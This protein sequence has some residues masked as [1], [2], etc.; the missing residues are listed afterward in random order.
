MNP[1]ETNMKTKM[2]RQTV[3]TAST[4][5]LASSTSPKVCPSRLLRALLP[6]VF[7][8]FATPVLALDGALDTTWYAG[9]RMISYV[10]RVFV[11]PAGHVYLSSEDSFPPGPGGSSSLIRLNADGS[12]DDSF[13]VVVGV[14]RSPRLMFQPDGKIIYGGVGTDWAWNCFGRLNENGAVD[15][16]H[17]FW[18]PALWAQVNDMVL[19]PDGKIV[20]VGV[21]DTEAQPSGGQDLSAS[22]HHDI[23]RFNAD[24]TWDESFPVVGGITDRGGVPAQFNATALALR[25]DGKILVGGSFAYIGGQRR[26]AIARLNPDG[27]LD[28]DFNTDW[29]VLGGGMDGGV[30]INRIAVLADDSILVA[31]SFSGNSYLGGLVRLHADGSLDL[32][33]VPAATSFYI[34]SGVGDFAL[35]ADGRILIVGP[36]TQVG[37]ATRSQ[38]ARLNPDGSLDPTF[39]PDDKGYPD[40]A[41]ESLALQDEGHLLVAGSFKR[42]GGVPVPY[43]ARLLT[44]PAPLLITTQPQTQSAIVGAPATWSVVA[45]GTKPIAYQWRKNGTE[46]PGATGRTL[47]LPTVASSDAGDY[48]VIVTNPSGSLPST[49]A[50]LTVL[51]PVQPQSY[52]MLN[53]QNWHDDTYSGAGDPNVDL[54]PL[55][56]GLGQLSDGVLGH[57]ILDDPQWVPPWV[58]WYSALH[59]GVEWYS[60]PEITFDFGGPRGFQQVA[61]HAQA[62]FYNGIA[63]FSSADISFSDDGVAFGPATSYTPDHGLVGNL[64][65]S[66]ILKAG[67]ASPFT[68]T[69]EQSA[70]G[71]RWIPI[72]VSGSGRFV[73]LKLHGPSAY[74]ESSLGWPLLMM[75]SELMFGSANEETV[76]MP[77][78]TTQPQSQAVSS[79]GTVSFT[80]A[81]SGTAPLSYQWRKDEVNLSDGGN[82]SGAATP[83]L[84]LSNVQSTDAGS[85]DVV[86]SN[87]A[88]P[89]PSL[90]AQLTV[91]PPTDTV[92]Q[93]APNQI[94]QT[95]GIAGASFQAGQTFAPTESGQLAEIAILLTQ[96]GSRPTS[97][98]VDLRTTQSGVP[99]S[100]V[101]GTATISGSL[102]TSTPV[103]LSADFRALKLPISAGTQYAFTLR[104]SSGGGG[105]Y[106]FGDLVNGYAAGAA[107]VSQDSGATWGPPGIPNDYDI[108]FHVT[109]SQEVPSLVVTTTADTVANDGQT[110]LREA[111]TYANSMNGPKTVSFNIPTSDP[112][113]SGGVFMIRPLSALPAITSTDTV[114]DGTTQTAFTGDSNPAGP[115]IVINGALAMASDNNA[116]GLVLQADRGTVRGLVINGFIRGDNSAGQANSGIEIRGAGCRVAGCYL[117]T[118]ATGA[119]AVPN[120]FGIWVAG[121][122]GNRI[123]GTGAG[124]GN[125]ISANRSVQ[126]FLVSANDNVVQGNFIGPDAAGM[127]RLGGDV[128]SGYGIDAD[129]S[130]FRN[131]IGGT[132]PGARNV[133]SGLSSVGLTLRSASADN[134]VLGNFIGVATDGVTPLGDAQGVVIDYGAVRNR[135]GG[136]AA[137]EGN[138]IAFNQWEGVVIANPANGNSIRGNQIF[139]NGTLGINLMGGTEDAYGVTANDLGDADTGANDLQNFPTITTVSVDG[140]GVYLIGSLNSTPSSTFNLDF[141]GNTQGDPSGHGEG[142]RYLGSAMV[143]TDGSGNVAFSV[144]LPGPVAPGEF[145]TVTATDAGTGSTSE[146]SRAL[147]V[148]T[149]TPPIPDLTPLPTL[150]GECSVTVATRPT[151]T[152]DQAVS[153][154]GTTTDPLSYDQQGIYA[155]TWHYDDGHGNVSSQMQ[156]VIVKDTTPPQIVCPANL[157]VPS[158]VDHLVPVTFAVTAT[159]NCDPAPTVVTSPSS[160]SLFPV[161]TTTVNCSATDTSGNTSTCSFTVT[162]A[163]QVLTA[164][165]PAQAWIG[166][167]NSDDVG[168]KFD[169]L[170]EVFKNGAVIGSGE[171]DG[172]SGGSSGFNNAILRT[173]NTTLPA[174]AVYVAG[175]TLSFRLSVRIA[176]NVAGHRSGTARLWFNDAAAN[177]DFNATVS[178]VPNHFFLLNGF[179][180][181]APTGPGPKQTI[182]VLVDKAVGGNPFKPFGTWSKTF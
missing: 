56:G 135:I 33:F 36:F 60:D 134:Q 26:N 45:T 150:T 153:L 59:N 52:A 67:P 19:Q 132:E 2:I 25:A 47:S 149:H 8:A 96:A 175:D 17:R 1:Y 158:S 91:Q 120:W 177:S 43:V 54:S 11:D 138:R 174:N 110:S 179:A 114:I 65:D 87:A 10:H 103:L 129:S 172:V 137:G 162:V 35:Q 106:V 144:T 57:F 6:A 178:A 94:F 79:G 181:G 133:I 182:D 173:I 161:G 75:V 24:G 78:L 64:K 98:F 42:L 100:T 125:L 34:N 69:A 115:E 38:L 136:A 159:D 102:L 71:A 23:A 29:S 72:P 14:A 141:Y 111:I 117:G 171:L 77:N 164:L 168:T 163:G 55:S 74:L 121:A 85:Y 145:I 112:G 80:V 7:F 166:L 89:V 157:T 169:L 146:F 70:D 105:V 48:E 31:G 151:A 139:D 44:A 104:T 12:R 128:P 46:I 107:F 13:G 140:S 143:T 95:F 41:I 73:R 39:V 21:F 37:G 82:V 131:L 142:E 93:Y 32:G 154:T 22:P 76:L 116:D 130:S 51:N 97:V 53:G 176:V 170:A 147:P 81:A 156:T 109:A 18:T 113:Y 126:L 90:A 155:I 101:L 180:L 99:T 5:K 123:G 27:S 127:N 152:D 30:A 122:N 4:R 66:G 84:T 20:A 148:V 167:K 61:I 88:G 124:D 28:S 9:T 63:I 15:F 160:G 58:A 119:L 62:R 86:V 68:T 50:T 92:A 49:V 118:D 165:G 108:G 83:L 3:E 16:W 40:V